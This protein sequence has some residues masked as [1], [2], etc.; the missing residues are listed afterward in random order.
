MPGASLPVVERP[1]CPSGLTLKKPRVDQRVEHQPADPLL[2]PAQT[3]V[4]VRLAAATLAFHVL[5]AYAFD[6]V[7]NAFMALLMERIFGRRG[8]G[9]ASHVISVLETA[10]RNRVEGG[11]TQVCSATT[12]RGQPRP[13][14]SA[15]DASARN[16]KKNR[17]C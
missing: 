4:P 14:H 2:N 6:D 11:E 1:Y 9:R 5:S 16:V 12:M 8:F 10:V 3:L 15:R 13:V 7:F 17:A